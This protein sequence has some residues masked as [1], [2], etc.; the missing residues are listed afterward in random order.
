MAANN[1]RVHTDANYRLRDDIAPLMQSSRY[2]NQNNCMQSRS[3]RRNIISDHFVQPY[4]Q[5]FDDGA[6]DYNVA[7]ESELKVGNH[8]YY[9]RPQNYEA[10]LGLTETTMKSVNPNS[11]VDQAYNLVGG[12]LPSIDSN[13]SSQ[14]YPYAYGGNLTG[15]GAGVAGGFSQS[16]FEG[17]MPGRNPGYYE[18]FTY[19]QSGGSNQ[20]L[21]TGGESNFGQFK[22]KNTVNTKPTHAGYNQNLSYRNINP[23]R[24]SMAGTTPRMS[25][26]Y[27]EGFQQR[28]REGFFFEE[29]Y[30]NP[31]YGDHG[32]TE[33]ERDYEDL[34]RPVTQQEKAAT[35]AKLAR[36]RQQAQAK[37]NDPNTSER[38][39]KRLT[40][41]VSRFESELGELLQ[42]RNQATED[43]VQAGAEF[44]ASSDMIPEGGFGN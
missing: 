14:Y 11:K 25:R 22:P 15:V 29:K 28:P 12:D 3:L 4:T 8:N 7:R 42:R 6:C 24:R 31:L 2:F 32:S 35:A 40:R 37:L 10:Q 1:F 27:N 34:G 41:Y 44:V 39:K 26:K 23:K 30:M 18:P 9:N 13:Q 20:V 17:N 43:A 36:L 16:G 19:K 5:K 21:K 38:D 33:Y